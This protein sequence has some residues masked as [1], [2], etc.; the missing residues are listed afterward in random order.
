M[1]R[2]VILQTVNRKRKYEELDASRVPGRGLGE[3]QE[4]SGEDYESSRRAAYGRF[5]ARAGDG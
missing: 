2:G 1:G 4:L 3:L 5:W